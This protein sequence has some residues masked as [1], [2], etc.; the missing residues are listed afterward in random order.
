MIGTLSTESESQIPKRMRR[1]ID[2]DNSVSEI[3]ALRKQEYEF[4]RERER[5]RREEEDRRE[6][7][8]E[9]KRR[10]EDL[11]EEER[12]HREDIK[13]EEKRRREQIK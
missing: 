4:L 5:W 11:K 9:E 1:P 12:R 6:K 8:E 3:R 13:E 2:N 7:R 10:R